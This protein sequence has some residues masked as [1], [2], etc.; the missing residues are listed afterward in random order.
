MYQ[1]CYMTPLFSKWLVMEVD[2]IEIEYIGS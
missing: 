1:E 2:Y